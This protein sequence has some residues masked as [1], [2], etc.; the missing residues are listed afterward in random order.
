MLYWREVC[1]KT[2]DFCWQIVLAVTRLKTSPISI[3][4][5]SQL[6]L[7]KAISIDP[8]SKGMILDGT[9]PRA[10]WLHIIYN[11]SADLSSSR[12]A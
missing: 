6:L 8:E 1:R 4:L 7:G 3:G 11:K 10:M 5:T 12:I 9:F 2:A